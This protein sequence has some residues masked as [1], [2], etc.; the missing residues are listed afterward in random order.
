MNTKPILITGLQRSGNTWTAK[1]LLLSKQLF[2]IKEPFNILREE[3]NFLDLGHQFLYI[4]KTNE[5]KYVKNLTPLLGLSFS[6]NDLISILG[7]TK[8]V[9]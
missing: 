5:H 8:N 7:R 9:I 2:A 6:F 3:L 4:N 1:M